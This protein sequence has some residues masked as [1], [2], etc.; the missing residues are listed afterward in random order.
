M[1]TLIYSPFSLYLA[2]SLAACSP[3]KVPPTQAELCTQTVLDYAELRDD[4]AKA[5]ELG[6]LF[7]SE[8]R[9]IFNNESM[10]RKAIIA[11]HRTANKSNIFT[12]DITDIKIDGLTGESHVSV[13]VQ[14]RNGGEE[15]IWKAQA[16]YT[17]NYEIVDGRCLISDRNVYITYDSRW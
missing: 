7:T 4:P 13:F 5:L 16:I 10:D 11:R 14:D 2:A 3:A 6:N 8:G 12:H 1:R 9:F 17:D 15:Y